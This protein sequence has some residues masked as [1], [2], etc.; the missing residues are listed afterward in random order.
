MSNNDEIIEDFLEVDQK[1]P[2]QNYCCISFISPETVIKNKEL[3]YVKNFLNYILG[4]KLEDEDQERV[5][6]TILDNLKSKTEDGGIQYKDVESAYDNWKYTKEEKVEEEFRESVDFQTCTRG[7]KVRGTYDTI[8]E[9]QIRAKV[10]QR[11]DKNFNVFVGQ[12]GYWLPWDPSPDSVSEQEYQESQLNQLMEKKNG[13]I[14]IK[15]IITKEEQIKRLKNL[16]TDYDKHISRMNHSSE[17]ESD[18]V[19][20]SMFDI[21]INVNDKDYFSTITTFIQS[22]V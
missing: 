18:I 12:V 2:G 3:Y 7:V 17:I 4:N 5:R 22:H 15:L 10:L 1:I 9:A 11:K 16:Y 20:D 13:Y 19:N 14:L 6:Q 21:I 8:R